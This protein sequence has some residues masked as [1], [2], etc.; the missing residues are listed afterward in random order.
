MVV[1]VSVPSAA[2]LSLREVELMETQ[3]TG[4]PVT[5]TRYTELLPLREVEL[6][7]T[8]R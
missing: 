8:T 4:V 7:E 2:L 6:M 5:I 1:R 3:K